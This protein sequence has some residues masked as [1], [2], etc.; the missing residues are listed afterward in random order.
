[1][2]AF[3]RHATAAVLFAAGL[4]SS[5]VY[6]HAHQQQA[7]TATPQP[8]AATTPEPG[9]AGG[10]RGRGNPTAQLYLERC[11]GCHGTSTVVGRHQSLFDDTW[12]RV[13]TDDDMVS[14]IANGIPQTEMVP[15]KDL[16][17]E[18]QIWQLVTYIRLQT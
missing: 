17:T 7:P 5:A 18:Q 1:M 8:P 10:G 14:V 11:A 15:Q 2:R 4:T 13:K 3:V 16:L 6:S 9:R 12:T